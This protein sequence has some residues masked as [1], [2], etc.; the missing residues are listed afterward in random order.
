MN[1]MDVL[2]D[3]RDS[4]FCGSERKDGMQLK[5]MYGKGIVYCDVDSD[6]RFEGYTDVLHGGMLFGIL[7]TII[8]YA[9][10]METKK[11]CT[12]HQTEM[13]FL[14]PVMCNRPYIAKGKFLSI[15]GQD[16]F[17][18][19]WVEN[20]KGEVCARVN[21][22]FREEKDAPAE[23]FIDKFDFSRTSPKIK[24]HFYSLLDGREK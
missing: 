7:D 2:P 23:R 18:K 9:V 11:I 24:Q 16:I 5:M 8:W 19:A 6:K 22:I 14:K 1:G 4:F 13:D 21:A 3:Y 15:K 10:F 20:E 17:A 12:T